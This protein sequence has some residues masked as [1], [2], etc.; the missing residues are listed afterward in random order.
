MRKTSAAATE[1]RPAGTAAVD[2]EIAPLRHYRDFD[3]TAR[4]PGIF[5][6][7]IGIVRAA[8][9]KGDEHKGFAYTALTRSIAQFSRGRKRGAPLLCTASP[10]FWRVMRQVEP[11]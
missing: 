4:H 3:L 10:G 9:S 6:D 7:H 1:K 5:K 2:N 8:D 11:L